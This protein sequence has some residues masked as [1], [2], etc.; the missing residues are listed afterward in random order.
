M[1]NQRL[2]AA[3]SISLA[4]EEGREERSAAKPS[5]SSSLL[6]AENQGEKEGGHG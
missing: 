5:F 4:L 1:K 2:L 6:A 3:F